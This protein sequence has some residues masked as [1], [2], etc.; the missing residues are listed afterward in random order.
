MDGSQA[1]RSDFLFCTGFAYLGN[2]KAQACLGNA[3]E[4]GRGVDKDLGDAYVWY[5]I[6]LDNPINDPTDKR[7]IQVDRDRVRKALLSGSSARTDK[8]LTDLIKAQKAFK[9]ECQ[10][11]V[12]DTKY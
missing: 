9:T 8:E 4:K 3:Y 2:Y 1:P 11:E 5:S 7:K 12:R 10:V 6:A